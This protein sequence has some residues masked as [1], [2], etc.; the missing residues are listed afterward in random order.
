MYN[1]WALYFFGKAYDG[2]T[3]CAKFLLEIKYTNHY[4]K[5][6][7]CYCC[8]E[9]MTNKFVFYVC[10]EIMTINYA[11]NQ[12]IRDCLKMFFNVRHYL[13]FTLTFLKVLGLPHGQ[14]AWP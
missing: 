4:T 3:R 6:F 13:F 14:A 1:T 5:N 11:V 2:I 7:V 12:L 8:S 9:I 10:S